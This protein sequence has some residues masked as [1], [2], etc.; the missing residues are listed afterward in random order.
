LSPI[1]T[2]IL[3]NKSWIVEV[4]VAPGI[5][6]LFAASG[7]SSKAKWLFLIKNFGNLH[8]FPIVWGDFI[9]NSKL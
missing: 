2:I 3:Y 1:F 6:L 5:Y 4:L 9:L 7:Y 8:N